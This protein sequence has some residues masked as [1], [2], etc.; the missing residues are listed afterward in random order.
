[1]IT[2]FVVYI[3][4]NYHS[5]NKCFEDKYSL[6]IWLSQPDYDISIMVLKDG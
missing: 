2:S 1:M 5:Y 4:L 6:M 3:I